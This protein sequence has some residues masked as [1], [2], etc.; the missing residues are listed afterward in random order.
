MRGLP[1]RAAATALTL[2]SAGKRNGGRWE[3]GAVSETVP[4]NGG[5]PKSTW[6]AHMRDA[7][8]VLDMLGAARLH[9]VANGLE[10]L[11]AAVRHAREAKESEEA[12]KL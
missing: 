4:E 10:A 8:L 9:R 2:A 7:G 12:L 1:E 3:Y 5:S 6:A 11:D